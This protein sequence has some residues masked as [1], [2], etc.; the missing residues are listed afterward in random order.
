M[1]QRTNK[2]QLIKIMLT[3]I[4]GLLAIVGFARIGV[5]A[6]TFDEEVNRLMGEGNEQVFETPQK[7]LIQQKTLL[8]NLFLGSADN[9]HIVDASKRFSDV[10]LYNHEEQEKVKNE[11]NI[12][13]NVVAVPRARAIQNRKFLDGNDAHNQPNP[14]WSIDGEYGFV[15][16]FGP[17]TEVSVFKEDA[18]GKM[19]EMPIYAKVSGNSETTK[20]KGTP[21]NIMIKS[22]DK[23]Y[24][25]F[26]NLGY[27]QGKPVT[28]VLEPKGKINE[29]VYI[30]LMSP[31]DV[32]SSPTSDESNGFMS[33]S[34]S[35]KGKAP[36]PGYDKIKYQKFNEYGANYVE[37]NYNFYDSSQNKSWKNKL[38]SNDDAAMKV[39]GFYTYADFDNEESIGIPDSVKINNIYVLQAGG[40]EDIE[41]GKGGPMPL[42]K[43]PLNP[44]KLKDNYYKETNAWDSDPLGLRNPDFETEGANPFSKYL[45]QYFYH[46]S[47]WMSQL[48]YTVGA[49]G[50]RYFNRGSRSN[51]APFRIS[52]WLSFT[53]EETKSFT[54]RIN[55]SPLENFGI[56]STDYLR[57]LVK[58]EDITNLVDS[59]H[60]GYLIG[61]ENESYSYELYR[62]LMFYKIIEKKLDAKGIKQAKTIEEVNSVLKFEK[63]DD[64]YEFS[65]TGDDK[66]KV[67]IP[68]D[69]NNSFPSESELNREAS[70]LKFLETYH[71]ETYLKYQKQK[72]TGSRIDQL[73]NLMYEVITKPSGNDPYSVYGFNEKNIGNFY[74]PEDWLS[75]NSKDLEE[76]ARMAGPKKA[77]YAIYFFRSNP[78]MDKD[79]AN[80]YIPRTNS[81][82][83]NKVGD[84][85][86]QYSKYDSATSIVSQTTSS[87][88][89]NVFFTSDT[90][91]PIGFPHPLKTVDTD[92]SK[93]AEG[94]VKN[95][96]TWDVMQFVPP[97]ILNN[98]EPKYV[99]EDKVDPLLKIV[100]FD[101]FDVDRPNVSEKDSW[102][103]S[104]DDG[105]N[106]GIIENGKILKIKPTSYWM[107]RDEFNNRHFV[108]RIKT[109]VDKEAAQRL[110]PEE[111]ANYEFD[112]EGFT[113]V[114]NAGKVTMVAREGE[115]TE[116]T[117]HTR[118]TYQTPPSDT[119]YTYGKV[120]LT[121]DLTI[122]KVANEDTSKKLK[123]AKFEL[124][125][126]GD[127]PKIVG[128]EVT[129]DIGQLTFKNVPTGTYTLKETEAPV[130]YRVIAPLDVKVYPFNHPENTLQIKNK[131]AMVVGEFETAKKTVKD[132]SKKDINGKLVAYDQIL[133]YE[134]SGSIKKET[135]ATEINEV[136]LVDTLDS[137]LERVSGTTTVVK[138]N[139]AEVK[140]EDNKVW[141]IDTDGQEFLDTRSQ[142]KFTLGDGDMITFKF[143]V[144]VK[145]IAGKTI[146]NTG[147]LYG[148]GLKADGSEAIPKKETNTVI[149]HLSE[150]LHLRQVIVD[151]NADLA[152]PTGNGK[153]FFKVNNTDSTG[154]LTTYSTVNVSVPSGDKAKLPAFKEV[155]LSPNESSSMYTVNGIVPE[156]YEY[157][158]YIMSRDSN[159]VIETSQIKTG[160]P[161]VDISKVDNRYLTL[162]M[163]PKEKNIPLFYNWDYK[164]NEFNKVNVKN[165][166]I[167]IKFYTPQ[168]K[169]IDTSVPTTLIDLPTYGNGV[170][171]PSFNN[172]DKYYY[173]IPYLT[174]DKHYQQGTV[175]EDIVLKNIS[176]VNNLSKQI[177]IKLYF[178]DK[179]NKE[180]ESF[181]NK[182]QERLE[183]GISAKEPLEGN[184]LVGFSKYEATQRMIDTQSDPNEIII[185][186][187]TDSI[188][189]IQDW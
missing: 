39:Q 26:T 58:Q 163:A 138:N 178:T 74:A 172:L 171:I 164:L 62:N 182:G 54:L 42:L 92:D 10:N 15:P 32:A 1:K 149:N 102:I 179:N 28:I 123:G 79:S 36:E 69:D 175:L 103:T 60:L 173:R 71:G 98:Y 106:F 89:S 13:G 91:L 101:I 126:K 56:S 156:M 33:V 107:Q 120:R 127:N 158:G 57:K 80:N 85:G 181:V 21:D 6:P 125:T 27:Y 165:K 14:T 128:T 160:V 86:Y 187:F 20:L 115:A 189:T 90:L 137:G 43:D 188:P 4:L 147:E 61:N 94:K 53:Y 84:L 67:V 87:Q 150:G 108:I 41:K 63:V 167:R 82:L 144:K 111:F 112:T 31:R 25:K 18:S 162:I 16:T 49:D 9:T 5:A 51:T 130:N 97:R 23:G 78:Y 135:P 155:M 157:K 50:Y 17:N 46:Q 93:L 2:N 64:D 77:N 88:G 55:V 186:Y 38:S 12:K 183:N 52:N 140:L 185:W 48:E 124:W 34:A 73:L 110:T 143:K 142:N 22:G 145:H 81:L 8:P 136:S 65:E 83:R 105:E 131:R 47:D 177:P 141:S 132:E 70:Y 153:G 117:L 122:N 184:H 148:K 113:H 3:S 176:D 59:D 66:E 35:G 95:E 29:Q 114:P 45:G 169:P 37:I 75:I 109:V 133:T 118:P 68:F 159:Q 76:K 152:V 180:Q 166:Q 168:D 11:L 161:K 116:Y 151:N 7:K 72:V 129:N 119:S 146:K 139:E 134:V 99:F 100:D 121:G 96:I 44:K 40:V 30:G 24:V 104:R 154:N 19:E 174:K 170:L